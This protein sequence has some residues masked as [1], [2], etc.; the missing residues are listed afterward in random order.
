MLTV[1]CIDATRWK[2]LR[3]V[4]LDALRDSPD[5]FW[6]TWN[7]ENRYARDDWVRF[8]RTVAWFVAV[9]D[10]PTT[11]NSVGLVGC[12]RRTEAPD[13]S[14]IIGMWVRPDQRGTGTA[15]LL[16]GAA[17]HWARSEGARS[18]ALWVID[19]NHRARR[20]YERHDYRPTGEEAPLPA[21]RPGREQRMRRPVM[22]PAAHPTDQPLCA[23]GSQDR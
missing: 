14:E 2:D 16:I 21:G 11:R 15:D 3:E 8:T 7:D 5:A 19:S 6:A 13:E 22:A 1:E 9:H 20:F 4:R 23:E 18:L 10:D 12:L 17:H